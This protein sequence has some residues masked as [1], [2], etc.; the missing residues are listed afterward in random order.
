ML[1]VGG[2]CDLEI[3]FLIF[4]KAFYLNKNSTMVKFVD[5]HNV[6]NARWFELTRKRTVYDL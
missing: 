1:H 2:Y 6:A 3:L 4:K 5:I